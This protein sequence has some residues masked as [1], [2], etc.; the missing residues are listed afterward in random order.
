MNI[1]KAMRNAPSIAVLIVMIIQVDRVGSFGGR[2]GAGFLAWVFAIFLASVIY[3]LSY[4]YARTKYEITADAKDPKQAQ[5]YAAQKRTARVYSNARNVAGFWLFMFVAIEGSLNFFETMS[6]LPATVSNWEYV[7][8]IVYGSFPTLAAFGLGSLQALLDRIPYGPTKQSA[9]Q[10]LFEKWVRRIESQLDA[11]SASDAKD[12]PQGAENAP[13]NAKSGTQGVAYPV[14]CPHG[15]GAQLQN[16]AEYSAHVGRWCVVIRK[17][18]A[19]AEPGDRMKSILNA[20]TTPKAD[21][22]NTLFG[23]VEVVVAAETEQ[24]K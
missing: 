5:K 19:S 7:G 10:I 1:E 24:P 12:A 2:I 18:N 3:V 21:A 13:Q 20:T 17:K 22:E 6:D 8:A 4:W 11:Q 14:A 15:C 23:K 9:A 16:A